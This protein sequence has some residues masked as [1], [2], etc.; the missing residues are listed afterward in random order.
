MARYSS[1]DL[2]I[3]IGGAS[4]KAHVQDDITIGIEVGTE[5]STSYGSAVEQHISTGIKRMDPITVGGFY[6]DT[7]STGPDAKF[8][9]LGTTITLLVEWGGT[10]TTSVETIVKRYERLAKVGDMTKYVATLQPTGAISEA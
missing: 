1:K 3:K 8:N 5:E 10:K 7:A 9:T 4:I 6:D 2:D